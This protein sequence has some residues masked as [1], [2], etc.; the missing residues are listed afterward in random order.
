MP[1]GR[2]I[3]HSKRREGL[4]GGRERLVGRREG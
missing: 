4:L 2:K 1:S 3:R